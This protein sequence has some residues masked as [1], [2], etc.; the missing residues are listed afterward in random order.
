MAK[1]AV[2]K[3]PGGRPPK[4]P[5]DKL[6]QFSIRLPAKLKFGL[7]LLARAQHRSL[8]QAVEWAL[9]VGLNSHRIASGMSLGDVVDRAWQSPQRSDQLL[10]IFNVDP[11]VLSFEEAAACEFV[12]NSG[13][14]KLIEHMR[15]RDTVR[16]RSDADFDMIRERE[17]WQLGVL[18]R[19]VSKHWAAI[20]ERAVK[21]K[22][23]GKEVEGSL[24]LAANISMTRFE[25]EGEFGAMAVDLGEQIPRFKLTRSK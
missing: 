9:L 19:F 12:W 20:T 21:L 7:E 15:G 23:A 16:A 24:I 25:E 18:Q 2:K 1:T 10:A 3:N 22:N 8:S 5:A 14:M 11:S 4:A 17:Q 6:E 13:E